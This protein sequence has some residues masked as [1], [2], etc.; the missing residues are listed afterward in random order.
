[1]TSGTHPSK[2]QGRHTRASLQEE[3]EPP[4]PRQPKRNLTTQNNR[5][6]FVRLL[7]N[8]LNG[9]P[10]SQC[11]RHHH[12]GTTDMIFAVRQLQDKGQ[13]MRG[14]HHCTFVDLTKAFDTVNREALWKIMKKFGC[15]ERFIQMVRQLHDGRMAR[16]TDNRAVSEAFVVTNGVK[17][18]Y[19]LAPTLFSLIFSAMLMDAYRDERPGILIAYRT[20]SNS[21]I[22]GGCTFSRV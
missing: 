13:E 15:P 16:V 18:G 5:K 14:H 11:G 19:V 3:R 7:L 2:F 8:R 20:D 9:Y 6:I 1:M 10:Q 12:R 4:T 17:H 22:V 21:A